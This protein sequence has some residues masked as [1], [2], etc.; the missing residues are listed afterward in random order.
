MSTTDL[1]GEEPRHINQYTH[2]FSQWLQLVDWRGNAYSAIATGAATRR[3]GRRRTRT[4]RRRRRSFARRGRWLRCRALRLL[5]S[6]LFRL[7]LSVLLIV[8]VIGNIVLVATISSIRVRS[9][10]LGILRAV[11]VR[12]SSCASASTSC[13]R[14]GSGLAGCRICRGWRIL[15]LLLL[16]LMLLLLLL[17]MVVVTAVTTTTTITTT[18]AAAAV[19]MVTVSSM[20]I[21]AEVLLGRVLLEPLVLLTDVD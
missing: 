18:A 7:L 4:R 15:L 13:R 6:L 16:L 1:E 12:C 10:V 14:R 21:T 20:T 2:L 19:V 3:R 8:L 17:V 11:I 5:L 9:V